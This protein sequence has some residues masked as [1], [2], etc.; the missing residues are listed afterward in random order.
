MLNRWI[1]ITAVTLM[2]LANGVVV[3]REII[4]NWLVGDPPKPDPLLLAGG[5]KRFVQVAI[6]DDLGRLVGRSWTRAMRAGDGMATV[7]TTTALD[8]FHLPTGMRTPPVQIET[9]ISYRSEKNPRVDELDFRIFGLGIAVHLHG[10]AMASGEFPCSW[11]IGN[12]RGQ[13]VLN[14]RAP[15]A[16]GDMI[17]PF[18]RLPGL[19]VG[20]TWKVKLLDPIAQLV[21][22]IENSGFS[23]EPVMIT[24]TG[25]EPIVHESERYEAFTVEGGGAKAWV[26]SDGRV[27]RQEVTLPLLGRLVL[28]D[29]PYDDDSRGAMMRRSGSNRRDDDHAPTGDPVE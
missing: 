4:P 27:L 18:D 9:A 5:E 24:V 8:G 19:Y 15:A 22:G 3:W 21:P 26:T 2:L 11:Q 17:R 12:E 7:K 28:L 20:R 25:R 13:I 10:E 16:L 23:M 14:S 29:E 1:G 6:Y